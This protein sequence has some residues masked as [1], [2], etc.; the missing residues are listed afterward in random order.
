[1]RYHFILLGFL[2]ML[3]PTGSLAQCPESTKAQDLLSKDPVGHYTKEVVTRADIGIT[4]GRNS[5][6]GSALLDTFDLDFMITATSIFFMLVDTD[7]RSVEYQ[8]DLVNITPCLHIDL[9]IL[10]AK[11]EEVRC[12]INAAYDRGSADGIQTLKYVAEYLN[13]SY[14][15]LVKGAIE[16]AYIDRDWKYHQ[17]FEPSFEGSCCDSIEKMCTLMAASDCKEQAFD[18]YPT[19]DKCLEGGVCA[20]DDGS[21]TSPLYEDICPFDS[22]YLADNATG[23]GCELD[24]YAAFAGGGAQKGVVAEAE[25]ERHLIDTHKTFLDDIDHIRDSTLEMDDLVDETMLNNEERTRLNNFGKTKGGSVAHKRVYGCNADRTP[26]ER[27]DSTGVEGTLT[28]GIKPSEEWAAIPLRSDFSI[29]KDYI[30]IWKKFFA[31]QNRFANQ[32]E[33][34]EYLRTPAEFKEEDK[35]KSVME[36][37]QWWS[38]IIGPPRQETRDLWLKQHLEQAAAEASILPKAHNMGQETITI[39]KPMRPAMKRNIDLVTNHSVGLRKFSKGFAYLLRRSCIDR[40]CNE[41]LDQILKILFSN[42]CF[43]YASGAF[44]VGTRRNP[45]YDTCMFDTTHPTYVGDAAICEAT[46]GEYIGDP[47]WKKCKD[48]VDAL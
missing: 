39:L 1:M 19:H 8:R 32:R 42:E 2:L 30:G 24:V 38:G 26:E 48:A 35:R 45:E 37:D 25:A 17:D 36:T 12:E 41:R 47:S 44:R 16:P 33:Y 11:M 28:P 27:T 6:G 40:P 14:K 31:L 5:A 10:E 18:F 9:A 13:R 29:G 21:T 46:Y 3:L 20:Y 7:L 23:Y 15:H 4:A 43:P 22:D 34:P